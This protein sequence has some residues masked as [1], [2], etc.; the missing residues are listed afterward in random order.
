MYH[1]LSFYLDT[2]TCSTSGLKISLPIP[3]VFLKDGF[4]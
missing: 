1:I 3:K 4:N 2:D